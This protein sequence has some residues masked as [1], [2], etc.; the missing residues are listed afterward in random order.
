M[1]LAPT[2]PSEGEIEEVSSKNYIARP[3][4]YNRPFPD[5]SPSGTLKL[6]R[7]IYCL[8]D[9]LNL[10]STWDITTDLDGDGHD[11]SEGVFFYV[12]D[13]DV[14]FNGNSHIDIHAVSAPFAGFDSMYINY[15]LYVPT[16]NPATVTITGSNGSGFT[17][18]I[19]A[20]ASHVK[21]SGGSTTSGGTDDGTVIIDAQII[22]FTMAIEGNGTLDIVYNQS[23]NA[24]TNE[25]PNLSPTK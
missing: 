23:K 5:V 13:G 10:N 7:G 6:Q 1:L 11:N 18:T 2:C 16:T 24:V 12:P 9:G 20:P 22:G 17:G 15:L 14:T 8:N 19:L 21:L 4:Y 3:G 25:K